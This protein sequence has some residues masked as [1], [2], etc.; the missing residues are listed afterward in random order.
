MPSFVTDLS[1][2]FAPVQA[3]IVAMRVADGW[4]PLVTGGLLFGDETLFQEM[5]PPRIVIVPMGDA[6]D[7][8][9]PNDAASS[10]GG[11]NPIPRYR[12]TLH[13]EAHLWGDPQPSPSSPPTISD[14]TWDFS[15]CLELERELLLALATNLG[16]V[17]NVRPEGSE[18]R[19]PTNDVR[20]GRL[21]VLRF[22]VDT[23]IVED[24]LQVLPFSSVGTPGSTVAIGVGVTIVDPNS[25]A[26]QLACTIN[27]GP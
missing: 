10:I 15:V 18:F 24:A 4:P 26:S 20:L 27:I 14:L 25:G 2:L 16:G 13:F 19:Q 8:M 3:Q 5:A 12:R 23:P 11:V 7:A 1:L 9:R 22:S 21:L 6:I 17:C